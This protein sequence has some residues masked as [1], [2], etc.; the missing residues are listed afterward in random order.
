MSFNPASGSGSRLVTIP[1]RKEDRG[2]FSLSLSFLRDH[3]SV[4]LT[5]NV[6]VGWNN[7]QL[8]VSFETFRDTPEARPERGLD[9]QGRGR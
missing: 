2:G 7:K 3:Q 5:R 9:R 6:H 4:E 1:I 8:K